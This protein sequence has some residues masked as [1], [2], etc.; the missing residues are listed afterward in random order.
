MCKKMKSF[1]QIYNWIYHCDILKGRDAD[2]FP[3]LF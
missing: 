1:T 3:K 2:H